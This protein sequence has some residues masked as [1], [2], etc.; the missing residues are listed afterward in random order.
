MA[1]F[2]GISGAPLKGEFLKMVLGFQRRAS[3]KWVRKG[4]GV[5]GTWAIGFLELQ[6]AGGW[7]RLGMGNL[8]GL[9][10]GAVWL[11]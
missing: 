6:G 8:K 7:V 11:S 4:S 3:S 2:A 1:L 5:I 9:Y 10:A